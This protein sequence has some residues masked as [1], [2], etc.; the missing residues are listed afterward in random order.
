[1]RS[2]TERPI[3]LEVGTNELIGDLVEL[4]PDKISAVTKGFRKPCS[5]PPLWDG[6]AATRI[7]HVMMRNIC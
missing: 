2:N 1:L 6:D 5:I 4:L 7:A 3:T